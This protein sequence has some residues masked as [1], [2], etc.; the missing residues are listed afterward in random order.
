MEQR[1]VEIFLDASVLFAASYS[2]RGASREIIRYAQ[3][4]QVILAVNKFIFD[5]P[6]KNLINKR[7]QALMAFADFKKTIPFKIVNPNI[8]EIL[9]M[10]PHTALKDAPHF[11]TALKAKVDCIVSLDRRHMVNIRYQ[12]WDDLSIRILL[13]AEMLR[14]IQARA[15]A[16]QS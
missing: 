6:E 12:V 10:L 8:A 16:L 11:A 14:E 9:K 1:Q 5:E 7:P 13:P 4:G 15:L 2:S 3:R